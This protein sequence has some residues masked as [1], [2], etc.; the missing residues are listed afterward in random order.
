[1]GYFI[2]FPT[3]PLASDPAPHVLYAISLSP[4]LQVLL[5]FLYH[6]R[7]RRGVRRRRAYLEILRALLGALQ[8]F[9]SDRL[10]LLLRAH[11]KS[12]PCEVRVLSLTLSLNN[13]HQ[14]L[15]EI[16]RYGHEAAL[17]P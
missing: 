11:S 14:F 10:G 13:S 7:P 2:V 5:S 17:I 9:S 3:S 8:Y 1:M 16:Q 12:S 15:I 4:A 6:A